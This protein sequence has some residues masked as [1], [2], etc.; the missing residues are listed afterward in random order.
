MSGHSFFSVEQNALRD[1]HNGPKCINV[2]CVKTPQSLN[3]TLD[4][5]YGMGKLG[6]IRMVKVRIRFQVIGQFVKYPS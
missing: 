6:G 2:T 5:K 3:H 1:A 4:G